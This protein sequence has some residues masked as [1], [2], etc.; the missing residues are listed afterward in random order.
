MYENAGNFEKMSYG[1]EFLTKDDIWASE[2]MWT[3]CE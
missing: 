1:S 2:L 3:I